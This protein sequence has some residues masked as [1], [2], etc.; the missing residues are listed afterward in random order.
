MHVSSELYSYINRYMIYIYICIEEFSQAPCPISS[1]LLLGGLDWD[2]SGN[3]EMSS[4]KHEK[5]QSIKFEAEYRSLFRCAGEVFR[6]TQFRK[7]SMY[8]HETSM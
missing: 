7:T 1:K 4:G 6:E 3:L 5:G 8:R 2:D